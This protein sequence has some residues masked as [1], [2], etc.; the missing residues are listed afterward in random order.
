[1][2]TVLSKKGQIVLPADVRGRLDLKPGDDFEVLVDDDATIRLRR[3]SRPPNKGLV[4]HLFSCPHP[5]AV[6]KRQRDAPRELDL[7]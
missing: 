4:A 1:M 3:V 5:F 7:G 2:T 6:P